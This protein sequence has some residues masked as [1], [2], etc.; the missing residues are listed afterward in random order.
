MSFLLLP[1]FPFSLSFVFLTLSLSSSPSFPSSLL[2]FSLFLSLSYIAFLSLLFLF[3]SVVFRFPC[4]LLLA[5]FSFSHHF[6][7]SSPFL[8]SSAL[9]PFICLLFPLVLYFLY[10]DF[11]LSLI[12]LLI[13]PFFL[14]PFLSSLFISCPC[15]SDFLSF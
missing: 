9:L 7:S 13:V 2:L 4:F 10:L 3:H 8:L 5:T 14:L 11:Y 6:Y 12:C 15:P 1:S